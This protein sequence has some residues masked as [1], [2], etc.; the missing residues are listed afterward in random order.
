LDFVMKL[1]PVEYQMI[2]GDEKINF[3]FIAQDVEKLTGT[4]NSILTIGGDADITLGLRYTDFIA[5]MV[6]AM[7]EQQ[8][9]IQKQHKEI[10][11]LKEMVNTLMFKK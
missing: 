1:R 6:K 9:E 2:K 8:E 3:G 7:Q 11:A 10:E 4:K 5:P